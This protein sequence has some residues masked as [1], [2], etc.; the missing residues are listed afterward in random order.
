MC[1]FAQELLA[2]SLFSLYSLTIFP[3]HLLVGYTNHFELE[4]INSAFR[5]LEKTVVFIYLGIGII[6]FPILLALGRVQGEGF[7][8]SG[9]LGLR[10]K[11]NLSTYKRIVEFFYKLSI[12]LFILLTIYGLIIT[13]LTI[14]N[15]IFYS[16]LFIAPALG[17]IGFIKKKMWAN[18]YGSLLCFLISGLFFHIPF[19]LKFTR[20]YLMEIIVSPVVACIFILCGYSLVLR[21]LQGEKNVADSA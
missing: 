2:A 10:K 20:G 6:C 17:L 12:F 21:Y 19:T 9:S 18:I 13:F 1:L 8:S 16:V 14:R 15:S 11:N 3:I 7:S 5:S 4:T